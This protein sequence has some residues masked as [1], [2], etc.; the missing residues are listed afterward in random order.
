MMERRPPLKTSK[1][2]A[3]KQ[4]RR[5]LVSQHGE[6]IR[7]NVFIGEQCV[8]QTT[9]LLDDEGIENAA[10]LVRAALRRAQ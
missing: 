8:D 3:A 2:T 5:I 1:R 6:F 9:L 7:V 4:P 10:A